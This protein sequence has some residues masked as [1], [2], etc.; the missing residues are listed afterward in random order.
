M[1][2]SNESLLLPPLDYLSFN[3][4]SVG[5]SLV[6]TLLSFLHTMDTLSISYT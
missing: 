2:S 1:S 3:A 6:I 4:T 5:H